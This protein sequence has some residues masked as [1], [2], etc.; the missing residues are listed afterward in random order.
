MAKGFTVAVVVLLLCATLVFYS[1]YNAGFL[2]GLLG[3]NMFGGFEGAKCELAGA[4]PLGPTGMG[5]SGVGTYCPV[6]LSK[7]LAGHAANFY[8]DR[9]YWAN[10]Q[11][12]SQLVY[13]DYHSPTGG[14]D[15]LQLL[16]ETEKEVQ[17]AN[18]NQQGDPINWDSQQQT[19]VIQYQPSASSIQGDANRDLVK[20]V[21]NDGTTSYTLTKRSFL[22]V[23]ADLHIAF[24]IPPVNSKSFHMS[25]WQEGDWMPMQ[26]WFKLDFFTW[27]QQGDPW[28]RIDG[29]SEW[30]AGYWKL[31][32]A[33]TTVTKQSNP[34]TP[35]G[36]FPVS[37]W[38]QGY[39]VNVPQTT[40]WDALLDTLKPSGQVKAGTFSP[41]DAKTN[42]YPSLL[43]RAIEL[44]SSPG[45]TGKVTLDTKG[46]DAIIQE[47]K[48]FPWAGGATV[49]A[50]FPIT[51]NGFG[52]ATEGNPYGGGWTV[53]YPAVNYRIRLIFC[54][55]GTFNYLWTVQTA[56]DNGYPGWETRSSTTVH[57]SGWW[58]IVMDWLMNNPWVILVIII[59]VI[60]VIVIVLAV[61]APWLLPRTARMVGETRSAYKSGK[62]RFYHHI[63]LL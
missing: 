31:N 5:W 11:P 3:L 18:L 43:G 40:N 45:Q 51:M 36:G 56:K 53:H 19:T 26:F 1:L 6:Q 47:A 41:I 17:L 52:T 8:S 46:Q 4:T 32:D 23:P 7:E 50:Y 38:I 54:V 20:T 49:P 62:S 57:V 61:V 28:N 59:G 16:I 21:N 30:D 35:G 22:L 55:W 58:E 37:G 60:A 14:D 63:C 25:G 13:W 34:Y 39:L 10:Y 33:N 29:S 9:V 12:T 15:Q 44:Y 27:Q 42:F 48:T 2:G 24:S